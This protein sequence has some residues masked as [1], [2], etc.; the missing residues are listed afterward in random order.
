[1][2][3]LWKLSIVFEFSRGIGLDSILPNRIGFW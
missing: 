3:E 1:M 2:R